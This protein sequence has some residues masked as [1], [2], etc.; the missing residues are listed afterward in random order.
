LLSHISQDW[1]LSVTWA[2]QPQFLIST[3]KLGQISAL[4]F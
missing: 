1:F 3:K 2:S 4:S